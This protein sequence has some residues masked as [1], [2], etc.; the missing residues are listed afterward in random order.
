MTLLI[1]VPRDQEYML[2]RPTDLS[3]W[4]QAAWK[5]GG[6]LGGAA[7]KIRALDYVKALFWEI[8]VLRSMAEEEWEEGLLQFPRPESIA[9]RT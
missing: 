5:K 7:A 9:A 8:L 1:T 4:V 6:I 2:T 3:T